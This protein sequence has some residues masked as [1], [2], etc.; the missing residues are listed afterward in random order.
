MA[1]RELDLNARDLTE[2]LSIPSAPDAQTPDLLS[3]QGFLGGEDDGLDLL[4]L[5]E[6]EQLAAQE[7]IIDAPET[8]AED[9][10]DVLSLEELEALSTQQDEEEEARAVEAAAKAAEPKIEAIPTPL[11]F[12]RGEGDTLAQEVSGQAP[13]TGALEQAF[14]PFVKRSIFSNLIAFSKRTEEEQEGIFQELLRADTG[15]LELDQAMARIEEFAEG[16]DLTDPELDMLFALQEQRDDL[17]QEARETFAAEGRVSLEPSA[18]LT[19]IAAGIFTSDFPRELANVAVRDPLIM[20]TPM[21][22]TGA[23][24]KTGEFAKALG[25]GQKVVTAAKITGGNLGVA[26]LASSLTYVTDA[27]EQLRQKGEIDQEQAIDAS[28][29]AAVIAP[30]LTSTFRGGAELLRR[31]R[32]NAT[33]K[34][35]LDDEFVKFDESKAVDDIINDTVETNTFALDSNNTL[36][37]SEKALEDVADF[38]EVKLIRQSRAELIRE[39]EELL[40][41]KLGTADRQVIGQHSLRLRQEIPVMWQA[42]LDAEDNVAR[43]TDEPGRTP[44]RADRAVR[45]QLGNLRALRETHNSAVAELR[46]IEEVLLADRDIGL[47]LVRILEDN[48]TQLKGTDVAVRVQE[49]K[50]N[51]G[52]D[53]LNWIERRQKL[54]AEKA[55]KKEAG[56]R[57]KILKLFDSKDTRS[58]SEMGARLEP[59]ASP[60]SN[61]VKN[62]LKPKA[63]TAWNGFV[64]V[65]F[66]KTVSRLD[67]MAKISPTAKKLRNIFRHDQEGVLSTPAHGQR[68]MQA[69][70]KFVSQ[71]EDALL[72]LRTSLGGF[73]RTAP[74]KEALDILRGKTGRAITPETQKAAESIRK[75][76]DNF[77]AYAKAAGHP[78][79]KIE[80]Y[81]PRVYKVGHMKKPAVA[82]RFKALLRSKGL[83]TTR[84]NEIYQ[85]IV[86][87]DGIL[88][89]DPRKLTEQ[90]ITEKSRPLGQ[91]S[92]DMVTDLELEEF[93]SNDLYDLLRDYIHSGVRSV[94]FTRSFGTNGSKLYDMIEQITKELKESNPNNIMETV[95]LKRILDL[96]NALQ[97]GYNRFQSKVWENI[98]A[99]AVVFQQMLSLP[100]AVL[101][102]ATEPF[103]GLSRNRPTSWAQGLGAAMKSASNRTIR[104]FVTKF[105]KDEVTREAEELGLI[106]PGATAEHLNNLWGGDFSSKLSQKTSA[107]FFRTIFLTQYTE[108]TRVWA[109]HAAKVDII[110]SLTLL[111]ED[112]AEFRAVAIK[113]DLTET[114]LDIPKGIDWIRRGADVKDPYY[115]TVQEASFRDSTRVI[116]TPDPTNRPIHFSSPKLAWFNML[117]SYPTT[118][119][120]TAWKN[121]FEGFT[122]GNAYYKTQHGAK[123]A[124]SIAAMMLISDQVLEL[125]EWLTYGDAGNPNLINET[126]QDR[127]FRA[128]N[129]AGLL[130]V[131]QLVGDMFSAV[132]YGGDAAMTRAGPL[133]GTV[134]D[135]GKGV[136]KIPEDNGDT[137]KKEATKLFPFLNKSA[138]VRDYIYRNVF[139]GGR[140]TRGVDVEE[141]QFK[142]LTP[143][144]QDLPS[145]FDRGERF[146]EIPLKD[147]D[148]TS[149]Q[150]GQNDEL[151]TLIKQLREDL[152]KGPTAAPQ[153]FS[154]AQAGHIEPTPEQVFEGT[155]TTPA[156]FWA[157]RYNA[158]QSLLKGAAVYEKAQDIEVLPEVTSSID[159]V[160]ESGVFDKEL[161]AR[162]LSQ[163]STKS[164]LEG[165]VKV[166]TSG[167][168]NNK[169]SK[170][171]AGGILQVIPSTFKEL[172]GNPKVI[173]DR[174]LIFLNKSRD[175]L[176]SMSNREIGEY[177]RDDNRA[178]ALFGLASFVNISKAANLLFSD[179]PSEALT[180]PVRDDQQPTNPTLLGGTSD[181]PSEVQDVLIL[182]DAFPDATIEEIQ[183]FL[184]GERNVNSG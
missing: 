121:F 160:V 55:A 153:I 46:S 179:T 23:A 8:D 100:F 148:Q 50:A 70:G 79:G 138:A 119:T 37:M 62:A 178:G 166:E 180:A 139:Q 93:L 35:L 43:L 92:L 173:G 24:A 170:G 14:K 128:A 45:A 47:E 51:M 44:A 130:G 82:A 159:D 67:G 65:T 120:N 96:A 60:T 1:I 114:G 13:I 16:R 3:P 26:A 168:R 29:I 163:D 34:Q 106:L 151:V 132:Q 87:K 118:F 131:G 182:K 127:T 122:K 10:L 145:I 89:F 59:P 115:K 86:S 149:V 88:D 124:A 134:S 61:V 78:V 27:A 158:D 53:D 57:P 165:I 157:K 20:L 126:G 52:P 6:L 112:V 184:E 41:Q 104:R 63:D 56:K 125:K 90:R 85:K 40:T 174:A 161:N 83:E 146:P 72:D 172:A 144:R 7:G 103:I 81:M 15:A 77:F 30:V 73:M 84:I 17:E 80:N 169:I 18:T 97:G 4:S 5:E 167:G 28:L 175:D 32:E 48:P 123:T 94:E 39:Q 162:G 66:G 68:T 91:R 111:S 98:M 58:W 74:A 75:L 42:V 183:E 11:E 181:A 143:Q 135:L 64:D 133:L 9:G 109:Q 101:T 105:P 136:F 71:L 140:E 176:L 76:L 113:V 108:M 22:Y 164:I 154:S 95:E 21:G 102:S 36:I 137:I 116:M 19:E 141:I 156:K 12:L 117:L 129:Q 107:A 142:T 150:Q 177:L 54:R 171:G 33:F 31:R 69:T 155:G 147:D 49:I 25:A 99:G 2:E 152:A 110:K 38:S